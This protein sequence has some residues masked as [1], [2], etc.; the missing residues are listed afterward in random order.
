MSMRLKFVSVGVSFL[1]ISASLAGCSDI[2]GG[3]FGGPEAAEQTRRP[4]EATQQPKSE[5]LPPSSSTIQQPTSPRAEGVAGDVELL[6][7]MNPDRS[8]RTYHIY[9]GTN[10]HNLSEH[11]VVAVGDLEQVNHP[12]YGPAYRYRLRGAPRGSELFIA[13][14]A[15]N[16]TA[17][18][19]RSPVFRVAPLEPQRR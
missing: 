4:S 3:L 16:E 18:S 17:E 1:L 5:S 14:S 9:Y 6:W 10:E 2:W 11:Q 7:K 13:L 8:I 12:V 15:E 19:S